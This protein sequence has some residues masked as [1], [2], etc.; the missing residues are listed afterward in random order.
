M[1]SLGVCR[2]R[3]GMKVFF[4]NNG[5]SLVV[6][7]LFLFALAGQA[8]VGWRQDLE[9]RRRENGPPVSFSGYLQSAEFGEAVFENWESEFLQMGVYV[10]LTVFL[11]QKGSSESKDPED[12]AAMDRAPNPG[13]KEV[14]WP[15]KC[16][17]WPLKV[18]Q[19][20]LSLAFLL[21]FLL[22]FIGH[23]IAGAKA[24]NTE[25]SRAGESPI[26]I[27]EY[28]GTPQFWFESLQNWESEFLAVFSIVVLSIWLREKGS[29]ESKPV[30]APHVSTGK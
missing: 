1:P 2:G 11:F 8:V 27:F 5:L 25:I 3:A 21:L 19:H 14:P 9:V 13:R 12:N 17:G 23:W 29:P 30:D 18:Y 26:S 7:S 20:S 15:V 4:K 24:Y 10:M 22:C 6:G 16:G 28:G